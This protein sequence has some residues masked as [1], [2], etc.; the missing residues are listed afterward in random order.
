MPP[1]GDT[2]SVEAPSGLRGPAARRAAGTPARRRRGTL[3]RLW[4]LTEVLRPHTGRF[5][6]ATITLVG[7]SAITL[8]YPQAVRYA[9]DEGLRTGEAGLLDVVAGAIT[10]L[11]VVQAGLTWVRHY[12]MTWLGQR[13]VAELRRR[14][15]ARLL[16]LEPD[17][18]HR[19]STG[20]LTGRLAA[21]VTVIEGV[22][23]TEISMAL[24]N[25]LTLLG[26]LVLLVVE[27]VYLTG[28]M[29]LVVPPL[30]LGAVTI[31]RAIRSR[32]RRVQDR[33]ADASARVQE[34]LAAIETVQAF[35]REGAEGGRY[36]E[37]V[38]DAFEA[39]RRLGL[40][41]GLFMAV[42]SL[43]GLMAIA[44]ILWVGGRMV[45]SGRLSGGD[46]AAFML[47]TSFVAVS[48]GSLAN[49]WG[50]IQRAAGAT[51]R[52]FE[53][54]D[55]VP[56]IRDPDAP[57]AL[58]AG[59]GEVRFEGV[60]FAYPGRAD[61]EV[62]RDIDLTLHPGE[63]VALVGRSGAGKSTLTHLL[64]RF[65]DPTAGRVLLDG[66]DLRTLRLEELRSCLATVSQEPVLFSGTLADNIAYGR[67]DAT[68]AEIEEAAREARVDRFAARL[69]DGYET[70]VGERG[71]ALSGG[72]RQ[73]VALARA[74]LTSPRVL[75]L[76]EATSHLD[77]ENEAAIQEALD[78]ALEGRTALVIAHRLSTVRRADRIVVLDD[79]RVVEEGTHQ[80]LMAEGGLYRHLVELELR[81]EGP[82]PSQGGGR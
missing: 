51:D 50:S 73:R 14:V 43:G 62:L 49:L 76:D 34:A 29:L 23:G 80:A 58:P 26:G 59:R 18:F 25:A 66:A 9:I 60:T 16:T 2:A 12:Q 28:L 17:Y 70:L 19:R 68:R 33:L 8:V 27:D 65:D 78:A 79:G 48:L 15:F 7:G 11:F 22:V 41:R 13:A 35:G 63:T 38:E 64:L 67:S 77:A 57:A 4:R 36:A 75:I 61:V 5:V 53:I 21:D 32:S 52:L 1:P 24:R 81:G 6:L 37:G 69:P 45:A 72:Q 54:I 44:L 39:A 46:L 20:E 82:D 40:W 31:G 74:L 3:S 47:Y 42:T 71:V 10:A 55:T 56:A 30:A